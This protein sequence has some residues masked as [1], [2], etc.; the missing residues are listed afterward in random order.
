MSFDINW[1]EKVYKKNKQ[2]NK[3]PFD[4][5]VSSVSK[6]IS[7]NKKNMAVELGCGTGNNLEFLSSHGY[8]KII[9]VDGSKSAINYAKK[10]YKKNKKI[11]LIQ[12]DFSQTSFE[13]VDL[14]L[15]RGSITHNKKIII[16][17][18]FKNL[19]SQLNSGGFFLSSLFSKKHHGYK[20]RKGNNFF[21]KE[22]KIQNGIVAS[23]FDEK[24]IKNLFKEFKVISLI[25]ETKLD[26][27]TNKKTCMWNIICKKF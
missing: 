12:A 9:G 24:E 4:W 23:F 21:V 14:F 5:V 11:K 6:Y 17:K 8:S 13:N 27:I 22:M 1:E 26:K 7:K 15:D 20:D 3:F 2:I 25:E 16:K 10:K 18:I 19:L